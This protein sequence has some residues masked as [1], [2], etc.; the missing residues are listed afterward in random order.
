MRKPQLNENMRQGIGG[1]LFAV[2][3]LLIQSL[4]THVLY[5]V[6]ASTWSRCV[7]LRH[8]NTIRAGGIL[9]GRMHR[10]Y[11]HT[12]LLFLRRERGVLCGRGTFVS[13]RV[14]FIVTQSSLSEPFMVG[15]KTRS[16]HMKTLQI[17]HHL[18]NRNSLYPS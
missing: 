17:S 10:V 3:S 1:V 6:N 18:S 11:G 4:E 2:S 13:D 15:L 9:A 8:I 14:W 16:F 12:C 5:W 7:A